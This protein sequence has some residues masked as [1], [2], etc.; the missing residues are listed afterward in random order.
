MSNSSTVGSDDKSR[1]ANRLPPRSLL[2]AWAAAQE[3][4]EEQEYTIKW[5][6]TPNQLLGGQVPL[7]ISV[8]ELGANVVIRELGRLE[9][10]IPP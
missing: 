5:M 9:H 7:L 4:F 10:G 3:V 6:T 1:S 2:R 8:D